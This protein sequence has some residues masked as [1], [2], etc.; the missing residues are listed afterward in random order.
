MFIHHVSAITLELYY[1]LFITY[2][3]NSN[4]IYN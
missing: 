4:E 1:I 3:I 2:F